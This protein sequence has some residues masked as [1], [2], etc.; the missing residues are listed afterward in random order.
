MYGHFAARRAPVAHGTGSAGLCSLLPALV[1]PFVLASAAVA[2]EGAPGAGA[3]QAPLR[4]ARVTAEQAPLYCWPSQVAEPPHYEDTLV[5][6]QVVQVGRTE[7]DFVQVLLPLGPVGYVS[8]RFAVAG[9]DG[10]VR[11]KGSKVS[12]RFRTVTTEAPVLQLDEGTELFVVGEQGDWWRARLPAAESWLPAAQ[13]EAGDPG[14][15]VLAAGWAETKLRFEQEVSARLEAIAA[16]RQRAEQQQADAAALQVVQDAFL[17]EQRKEPLTE[18]NFKPL[19]AALDKVD[20]TFAADSP[21]KADAARLRTRIQAQQWVVEATAAVEAPPVPAAEPAPK[22]QPKDGLEPLVIGW[23][24]YERK[25][26]SM[27]IFYLERGG[28]RQ[29]HVTCSS[30]RYDLSMF[31]DCEIG[32]LGPR[33][34]PSSEEFSTLDVERIEVLGQRRER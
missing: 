6:G 1:L 28:L 3:Q 33:R 5:K 31:V 22:A 19:L 14:D 29:H 20:A 8:K 13:L 32:V 18:Q 26:G 7:G 25:L 4:L 9:E 17:Q 30:G 21:A 2:Q 11:T 34:A 16:E 15:E 23:L 10:R 24:R 27:G 12:Y